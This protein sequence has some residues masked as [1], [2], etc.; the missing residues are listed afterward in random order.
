MRTGIGYSNNKDSLSSGREV[1]EKALRKGS[2]Q[3]SDIV[4]AFCSGTVNHE[5]FFHGLQEIVGSDVPIIGGSALGIIT[6]HEISYKGYPAGAAVIQLDKLRCRIA[7]ADD[8]DKGEYRAG[9]NIAG[10]LSPEPDDRLLTI[11]YDSIK[12]PSTETTTPI[13][14]A[15][16]PIIEG[17]E[18]KLQSN[19]PV[20]GAGLVGDYTFNTTK[21][22]CGSSVRSQSVVGLMVSGEFEPYC[23]IM[24]GCT[25]LDG[26]YRTITKIE[27]SVIYEVDN[28]PVVE[29]IDGIYE[30]QNW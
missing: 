17:I 9:T 30:N 22:F 11:F 16:S 10:Q 2:I 19:V 6:N 23:R 26:V 24:H 20:I 3:R 15:S 1:A 5:K 4:F 7:V 14:N 13:L 28:K 18:E 12:K 27:G 8:L 21:Q 29:I 25:P